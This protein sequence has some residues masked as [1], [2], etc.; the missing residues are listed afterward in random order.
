M[1]IY[2]LALTII[3]CI[4]LPL[5]G[6]SQTQIMKWQDGKE[7]CATLTYDDGSLNQ[8]RIALPL[9]NE[10][11]F[12][13]TF[14]INTGYLEGSEY[15]PTFVGRPIQEIIDESA[16]ISTNKNN[17]YERCSALRYLG[18]I[19]KVD[20]VKDFDEMK[21]GGIFEDGRHQEAFEIVDKALV[22]LRKS[23]RTYKVDDAFTYGTGY[24]ITWDDL[25]QTA[26][27][28]HEIGNHTISHPYLPIMDKANILYEV[29]KCKED[30]LNH[31][32]SKHSLSIECPYGI[33]DERVMEYVKS[34]FPFVR[35]RLTEPC[36][37]GSSPTRGTPLK[38][39]ISTIAGFCIY[40]I[41]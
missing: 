28:G 24:K 34:K 19:R 29:E 6:F 14:F 5:A 2:H 21:V 23:G 36:V 7:G 16:R 41:L 11:G 37:A 12:L 13:A 38:P 26:E 3:L 15:K 25:R 17:M 35:N 8:F 4:F 39:V 27:Q 20:A 1:K 22:A 9:M 31:L 18:P 40:R 30:I 10:R 33:E 32:G